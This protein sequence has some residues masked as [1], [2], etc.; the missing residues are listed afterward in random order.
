MI[1][2]ARLMNAVR[3]HLLSLGA[4]ERVTTHEPKNAPG[5]GLTA[6]LWI[7]GLAPATSGLAATSIALIW[8][9]RVYNPA[10]HDDADIIDPT[11][12]QAVALFM[13]SISSDFTLGGLARHVELTGDLGMTGS[14]GYLTQD[15]RI[16]R[17]VDVLFRSVHNDAWEQSA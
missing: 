5:K 8:N 16:Y 12:W 17:I 11:V 6:S 3:D 10:I 1:D 13:Q 9:L 4:F 2:F 7:D 15:S 14:A